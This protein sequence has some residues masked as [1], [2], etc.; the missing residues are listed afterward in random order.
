MDFFDLQ[1][2]GLW[3]ADK[4]A[5]LAI[6]DQVPDF[7]IFRSPPRFG[8]SSWLSVLT[9]YF[10]IHTDEKKWRYC[11]HNLKIGDRPPA[12]QY[13]ILSFDFTGVMWTYW[14]TTNMEEAM[15]S[16]LSRFVDKYQA[17]IREVQ[18][19]VN[20]IISLQL[21]LTTAKKANQK[22]ILFSPTCI[23]SFSAKSFCSEW[24]HCSL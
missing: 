22:V 6:W 20:L 1:D 15:H 19:D 13:L 10:D 18:L 24:V 21:V 12:Y 16:A 11:F 3:F 2:K 14:N 7:A 17:I 23:L 5:F 9:A 8:K 4:T